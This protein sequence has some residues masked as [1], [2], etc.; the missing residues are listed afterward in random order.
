M[1]LDWSSEAFL[2]M[3]HNGVMGKWTGLWIL[4]F[5]LALLTSICIDKM[6]L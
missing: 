1:D 4:G 6:V 5:Y 2:G 3:L